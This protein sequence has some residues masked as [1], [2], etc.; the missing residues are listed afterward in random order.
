M[1]T[2]HYVRRNIIM[3][4]GGCMK[5]KKYIGLETKI[6]AKGETNKTLAAF[7]GVNETTIYN[8]RTGITDFTVSEVKTLKNRLGLSETEISEIFFDC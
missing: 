1:L 7:L 5:P 2:L 6:M 3:K 4:G 8:K